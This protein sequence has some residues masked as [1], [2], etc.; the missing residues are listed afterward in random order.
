M[1]VTL[2]FDIIYAPILNIEG[3]RIKKSGAKDKRRFR[4][5]IKFSGRPGCYP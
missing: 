1:T 2:G 4:F 3:V 5:Y